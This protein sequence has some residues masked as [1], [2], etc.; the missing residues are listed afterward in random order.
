MENFDKRTPQWDGMFFGLVLV[1]VGAVLLLQNTGLLH[2]RLTR[3]FW[4]EFW[5]LF[6]IGLG[7]LKLLK[8]RRHGPREGGGL[9]FL[10]TWFLL[11]QMHIL[12]YQDSWPLLLVGM[13]VSIVWKALARPT[14]RVG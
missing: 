5:P 6:L 14:P 9:V 12:R 11:N 10:G 13:G 7:V 4:R 8:P 2:W 1:V 3:E